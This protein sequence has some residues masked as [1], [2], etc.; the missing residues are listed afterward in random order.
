VQDIT[1]FRQ[2]MKEYVYAAR[3]REDFMSG[4]TFDHPLA[5]PE[6]VMIK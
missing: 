4:M 5:M 1:R 2:D 3:V 6:L